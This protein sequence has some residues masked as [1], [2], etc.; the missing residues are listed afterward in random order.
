V[1]RLFGT[2][3]SE[4][5]IAVRCMPDIGTCGLRC[6]TLA[7]LPPPPPDKTGWPWT[8][9]TA[10][11]PLIRRDGKTWPRVSIVT[12]SYNQGR[13]IEETIRSVLLQGYP[14]LEYIIIDGGS[15][16]QSLVIVTKYQPWLAYWASEPDRGQSHAI[17]KGFEICSGEVMSWLNSDDVLTQGS[18]QYVG[19]H[20]AN[21]SSSALLAGA[22]EIRSFDGART[23]WTV[24]AVPN[25]LVQLYR[26]SEGLYLAQP[27]VFFRR[28]AFDVIGPLR[29]DLHYA[30][31]L[32]LWL[33][34]ARRHTIDTSARA[35]SWMRHHDDAKTYA[36]TLAVLQ[37]VENVMQAHGASV[38][39]N[40]YR[41]SRRALR[42]H[43]SEAWSKEGLRAY[44]SGNRKLAWRA[45]L[46][47]F[48]ETRSVL[49]KRIWLSLLLRLTFP[50]ALKSLILN[51]P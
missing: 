50:M 12:P 32:D 31:D 37:E 15:T 25:S 23:L 6:P 36:N 17:N 47:A 11:L 14:N 9:E 29:E 2:P 4:A 42:H 34:F 38:S 13:F 48:I 27:S 44:F 26:F 24:N 5:P 16:D 7:E 20:F 18:L 21:A 40:V 22:S 8:I 41:S 39:A 46:C 30:M 1:W 49:T 43:R 3:R 33:S 10:Q 28:E 19:I 45:V 35:L 51:R